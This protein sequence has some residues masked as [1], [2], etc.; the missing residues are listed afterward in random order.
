VESKGYADLANM[1]CYNFRLGEIECAI[2]LEQLKKLGTLVS[3][4][5]QLAQRLSA[6]LQGL[7]GLRIPVVKED[8]T[9]VYY[10]FRLFL[11]LN[12]WGVTVT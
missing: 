6:G 1:V 10:V 12:C 8:C 5:H 7:D 9:H 4:R 11:T 3:S 2:G